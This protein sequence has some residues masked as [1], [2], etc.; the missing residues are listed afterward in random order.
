GRAER[1]EAAGEIRQRLRGEVTVAVFREQR[2]VERA[3]LQALEDAAIAGELGGAVRLLARKE[4]G[5]DLVRDRIGGA[6]VLVREDDNRGGV[7][8]ENHVVGREPGNLAAVAPGAVAANAGD[9]DAERVTRAAAVL[10]Q[11]LA[12]QL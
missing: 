6:G 11:L 9:R 7:V 2:A 3:M 10:Q 8:G 4:H 5:R 12:G 1:P